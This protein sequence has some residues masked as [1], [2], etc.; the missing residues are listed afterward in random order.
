MYDTVA[1]PLSVVVK[2]VLVREKGMQDLGKKQVTPV[3]TLLISFRY[4]THHSFISIVSIEHKKKEDQQ[5]Q[6]IYIYH[7]KD[8]TWQLHQTRA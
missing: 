3:Y 4:K 5:L 1:V 7:Q 6:L 2:R 8:L